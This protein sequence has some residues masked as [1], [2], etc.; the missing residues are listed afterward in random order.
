[1]QD[2]SFSNA[3]EWRAK[4][5]D[6]PWGI[7][8]DQFAVRTV[9][10]GT[11]TAGMREFEAVIYARDIIMCIRF[12]LGHGPFKNNLTY[13]PERH[14]ASE[15]GVRVYNE[16]HTEDWWWSQQKLLPAGA[17]IVPLLIAT[18]KTVLTLHHGDL[19]LWPVYL[20]IGNLDVQTRK[21]Q[22]RPSMILLGLIPI[23]KLGKEHDKHLKLKIYHKAI[24]LILQ[25]E[26]TLSV[27]IIEI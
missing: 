19:S 24:E 23:L 22:T 4:I 18:D 2:C 11:D 5:H 20:T 9:I 16:M 8:N 3:D 12:L 1:M 15:S 10:V 7:Q 25:R 21:S 26:F 6:I 27:G 13:A 14:Y 17:T